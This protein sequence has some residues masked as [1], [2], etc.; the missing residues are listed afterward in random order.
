MARHILIRG[1]ERLHGRLALFAHRRPRLVL[2]LVLALALLAGVTA[3]R[4]RIDADLS[5]L[6]PDSFQSVQDLRALEDELGGIGYVVVVGMDAPPDALARFADDVAARVEALADIRYVDHLRPSAFFE[7][8][9][10]YFLDTA[11]LAE[12]DARIRRRADWERRRRNPMYVDLE[13]DGAAPPLD[14]SDLRA[15]YAGGGSAGPFA[16]LHGDAHILDRDARMVLVLAKPRDLASDLAF[17][18]R[19][20]ER[21]QRVVDQMDLAA[22]DP[23]LK[24]ALTGRYKKRIDQQAQIRSDLGLASGVALLLVLLY[25]AVH[26]RRGLAVGLVMGPLAVGLAWTFGATAALFSTLNV[27]T[28]FIG[29]ILLGLGIDHGIHL[30][31]RYESERA[32]GASAEAAITASF[33]ATGRAVA[34]AAITTFFAFAGIALSELRAF[35]E[36]GTIAAI[37]TALLVLAYMTALPAL[38][39]LAERGGWRPSE[40]AHGRRS[41]YASA[42]VRWAPALFWLAVVGLAWITPGA[43]DARFDY[44][45]GALEDGGLPSFVLDRETNRILGYSQT[46]VAALTKSVA[47]ERHVAQE[48]RSRGDALGAR[49]SVASVVAVADL[50]PA[51]QAAKH[52]LLRSIRKSIRRVRIEWLAEDL[53][54]P[55]AWLRRAA[56]AAPFA[57][58]DLPDTILRQFQPADAGPE[59]GFVLVFPAIS[60]AD[61]SRVRDFAAEVGS[62]VLPSGREVR[63][64]GEAMILAD[65]LAMVGR[66]AR[67]VLGSTVL[68]VFA[69]LWILMG[70]LRRALLCALVPT[71]TLAATLGLL[72]LVGIE[73]NYLNIVMIPVLLGIGVDGAIHVV[74][75]DEEGAPL[76]S[77]VAGTGR[78]VSGAILT[79][80]FGFGSMLLADHPGLE[81]LGRFALLGLAVN[82]LVTLALLPATLALG[83]RW[84]ERGPGAAGGG[85]AA[86]WA[87]AA[88]T[89]GGAGWAPIGPGTVGALV[90]LPIGWYLRDLSGYWWVAVPVVVT[91]LSLPA[92]ARYLA[93]HGNE[94]PSEVV[95]DELA[96]CLIALAFVPR[97][98]PWFLAAFV[99]FRVFDILKP[100]PIGLIDRRARGAWGVMGDDVVAGALA[101]LVLVA[102]A[103]L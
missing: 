53:R 17:S 71:T 64:I 95:V 49:S 10:L 60:L 73:L 57:R 7:E 41:P 89:V 90:A 42:F 29:A 62:V 70:S 101:G 27:L 103:H 80:A 35:R 67:P 59:D 98:I 61:G 26:F 32:G 85:W 36:F 16:A 21:V 43:R 50:V 23:G 39:A 102:L 75:R 52:E 19:V 15:R 54:E 1:L 66:E 58:G 48:L 65:V 51:E 8:R 25:L 69:C 11:D 56:A 86:R 68:L 38:L 2:S 94:D 45:F 74:T 76:A 78:A 91:L 88:S 37:G 81:S 72:P 77:I 3:S 92:V 5:A 63:A 44:D 4:L 24:A 99:L 97:T 6:L 84:A 47:E 100:G 30:L 12:V 55:F 13:G 33:V 18:K 20:V 14:F 46:P 83:R 31:G 40:A 28:G 82:L 9:A 93:G 22:Y 87:E 79:T 34:I 96:G